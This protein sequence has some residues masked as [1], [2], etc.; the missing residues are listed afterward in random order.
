MHFLQIY[1]SDQGDI[2]T[3]PN[4]AKIHRITDSS[5]IQTGDSTDVFFEGFELKSELLEKSLRN[6]AKIEKK[7]FIENEV[8]KVDS[9]RRDLR[10]VPKVYLSRL[11]CFY[12]IHRN[13]IALATFGRKY[14]AFIKEMR[15]NR[16]KRAQKSPMVSGFCVSN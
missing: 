8:R 6:N 3:Y 7:L 15:I 12:S 5:C 16:R 14:T 9:E 13:R 4:L 2:P 11:V 1:S 10:Y